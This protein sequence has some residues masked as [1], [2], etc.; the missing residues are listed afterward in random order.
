MKSERERERERER[1]TSPMAPAISKKVA[2]SK[3]HV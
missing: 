2:P 1:E 3:A